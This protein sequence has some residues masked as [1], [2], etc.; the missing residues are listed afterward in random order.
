MT[1]GINRYAALVL[2]VGHHTGAFKCFAR[3][4]WLGHH[5]VVTTPLKHGDGWTGLGKSHP[6]AVC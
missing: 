1:A 5:G 3:F 2:R 4:F 6:I